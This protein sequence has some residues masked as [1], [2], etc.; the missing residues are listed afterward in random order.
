MA[1]QLKDTAVIAAKW[2]SRSGSAGPEYAS[3]VAAPSSDWAQA[4][5][6]AGDSYEQG[7]TGAISRKAFQKGVTAAGTPKWQAKASSIGAARYGQGVAAGGDAYASGFAPYAQT[8]TG[9]TLPPRGAKGSPQ[10]IQRV[11]AVA[12]A[13][14]RRKTG[15]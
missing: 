3:G 6:A 14:H 11:S 2:K 5:A 12:D 4:T 13:L 8:L 1:I 10:N 9:L 15:Q 7:V